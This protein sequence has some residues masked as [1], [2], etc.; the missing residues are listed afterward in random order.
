M[1]FC[2]LNIK[3]AKIYLLLHNFAFEFEGVFEPLTK[4]TDGGAVILPHVTEPCFLQL[5][6]LWDLIFGTISQ[7]QATHREHV[8]GKKQKRHTVTTLYSV[9]RPSLPPANIYTH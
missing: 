4:H 1:T 3:G 5:C 7:S 6:D 2:S 8:G 9:N